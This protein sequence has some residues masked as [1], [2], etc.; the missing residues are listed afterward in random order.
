MPG[1]SPRTGGTV[2]GLQTHYRTTLLAYADITPGDGQTTTFTPAQPPAAPTC[3]NG[4]VFADP[5][6]NRELVINGNSKSTQD[7]KG[8]AVVRWSEVTGATHYTIMYRELPGEHWLPGWT[9]E[10]RPASPRRGSISMAATSAAVDPSDRTLRMHTI[11]G[12]TNTPNPL[13]RQKLYAMSINYTKGSDRYFAAREAYVW[14]SARSAYGGERVGTFP[15]MHFLTNKTYVYHFCHR[16]FEPAG[17]RRGD[18]LRLTNA[19]LEHWESAALGLITVEI[20]SELCVD[21]GPVIRQ[22]ETDIRKEIKR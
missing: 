14:P 5:A 3:T 6:D 18:W 20:A 15:L 8:Q 21:Y 9:V 13:E 12:T 11:G 19:A 17:T 10:P 16:T 2:G 4:T 7:G 1:R 22:L